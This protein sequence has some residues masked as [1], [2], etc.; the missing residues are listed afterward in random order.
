MKIKICGLRDESNIRLISALLPDM[1]GFIFYPQSERFVGRTLNPD[2][3]DQIPRSVLKVGVFVNQDVDRVLSIAKKYHLEAVQLH[4]TESSEYCRHIRDSGYKIIKAIPVSDK[5]DQARLLSYTDNIDYFLFDTATRDYGGSGKT[6]NWD[7]LKDYRLSTPF[8]LSGGLGNDN[9]EKI[10]QLSHP[11]LYGIDANSKL[12]SRPGFK[13]S[14]QT[15]TFINTI[16]HAT[17]SAR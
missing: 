13:N 11:Q 4:G 16:R 10:L 3:L 2:V 1:I 8:F 6:F 5:L 9:L 7:I 17:I 12:E 14:R 15:L